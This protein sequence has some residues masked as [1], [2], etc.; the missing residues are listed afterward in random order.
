MSAS[1]ENAELPTEAQGAI[2]VPAI[3]EKATKILE[4]GTEAFKQR[5]D[6]YGIK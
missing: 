2:D 5:M 1:Q 6:K 4:G 3:R